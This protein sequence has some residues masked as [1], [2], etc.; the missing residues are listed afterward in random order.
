MKK[1]I[2]SLMIVACSSY[3]I[4]CTGSETEV[5]VSKNP[6]A[7]EV[8]R[9][10]PQADIFQWEG[11]IYQ[12]NIDWVNEI[13]LT[14]HKSIGEIEEMY[15]NKNN[16]TDGMANK[17]SIGAKI[18]STKERKDILLVEYEGKTKTY[19]ALGEG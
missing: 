7:I 12:T 13:K 2:I 18:F 5:I 1:V 9:L 4:G 8:L 3:L 15:D 19:L 14:K 17:L 11:L 10:D 6:D 16:F